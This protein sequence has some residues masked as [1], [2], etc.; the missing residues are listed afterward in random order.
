MEIF[1]AIAIIVFFIVFLSIMKGS[2]TPRKPKK[3]EKTSDR[4]WKMAENA[5]ARGDYEE[6]E[7]LKKSAFENSANE[8]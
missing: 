2:N 1:A 6:Y 3:H 7:R 5:K 4:L 8:D